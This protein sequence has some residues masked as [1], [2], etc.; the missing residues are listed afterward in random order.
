MTLEGRRVLV[1]MTGGIACYKACDVVRQLRQAGAGVQVIM[2]RGAQSFV[3][4][5]TLQALSGA[6][7]ATDTFDLGQEATIGHIRLADAADV[8]LVAP[9]TDEFRCV[10]LSNSGKTRMRP[11]G[12]E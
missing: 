9:A 2:T 11:T 8:V 6:P 12:P 5:L 3:T 10:S 1:G 7:V 4:P